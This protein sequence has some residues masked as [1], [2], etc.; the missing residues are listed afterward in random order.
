MPTFENVTLKQKLMLM[1]MLTSSVA[2]VLACTIFIAFERRSF[3]AEMK[4]EL[5]RLGQSIVD[6][7]GAARFFEDGAGAGT[8]LRL[9]LQHYPNISGAALYGPTG[10]PIATYAREGTFSPPPIT[11]EEGVRFQKKT[12]TFFSRVV[13]GEEES[14]YLFVQSDLSPLQSRAVSYIGWV[15]VVLLASLMGALLLSSRLQRLVSEPLQ[16]L[17]ETA[18]RIS[19]DKNYSVRAMKNGGDEL[20]DLIDGFN[21]MLAQIQEQDAALRYAQAELE[22]RVQERTKELRLEIT[23][24]EQSEK[25]LV[26]SERKFRTLFDVANDA[27]FLVQCQLFL[28]CNKRTLEMFGA[29][30][31][32]IIGRSPYDFSPPL[33]PDGRNSREQLEHLM[34]RALAGEAEFFEW[35]HCRLDGTQFYAEVSLNQIEWRGEVFLQAIV[36]DITERKRAEKELQQQFARLSL[37]NHITRAISE[38]QDIKSIFHVVLAQLEDHLQ[39]DFGSFY[40]HDPDTDTLS[41]AAF[42]FK[43]IESAREM[44]VTRESLLLIEQTGIR[45]CVGGETIFFSNDNPSASPMPPKLTEY[46]MLTALA[47]P[48]MLQNKLFGAL[49]VARRNEQGFTSEESEFLRMLSDH[50]ALAAHQA[51]LYTELQN[52]YDELRLTQQSVMKQERLRALGEMASGIAHDINNSLSPVV[53]YS[54]LLLRNENTSRDQLQKYLSN[55]K[56]AGED[57]AHIVARMRE[58]YRRRDDREPRFA[59]DLNQLAQQVIEL[60]RPRWRDIPQ[61]RGIVINV[62]TDFHASLPTILGNGSELRE[63]LT[64]LLLNGIDAMPAGGTLTL[65]SRPTSLKARPFHSKRP[66]HVLF[67]ISDTGLGMDEETRNRC[68]EPFFST[69]GQRGTGLGLAMVYGVME[70]HEAHIEIDSELHKGTT[71]RLIFP[72]GKA[73]AV[74]TIDPEEEESLLTALRILCIDDEPLLRELMREILEADG[75]TVV[76]ADGGQKGL[77]VFRLARDEGMPFHVVFTDLGMPYVDGRQVASTMKKESPETPIIMLTGWGTMMKADGAKPAQVDAVLSKPPRINELRETMARLLRGHDL[78]GNGA[79]R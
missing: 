11:Q 34:G 63:A 31:D 58:F 35:V 22:K 36:R 21:A 67:E 60:T 61:E 17:A 69:K 12:L 64:N 5:S 54:E 68:L 20:G 72:T 32:E 62:E 43:D 18:K 23:E 37:I 38:R 14:G 44:D 75:H 40:L 76:L 49:L 51:R 73:P 4:Q 24:R 19:R 8:E 15:A 41:V 2:L 77:E 1:I 42:R 6:R 57:I 39:T 46:G 27:I 33:Q 47:E 70:R 29:T 13:H 50:V 78:S 74:Q 25:A 52:A 65:R 7:S 3:R 30:R 66:T 9:S 26:E 48:M 28:D 79:N 45:L 55:I 16:K 71:I 59:L 53:V 56:T 10:K